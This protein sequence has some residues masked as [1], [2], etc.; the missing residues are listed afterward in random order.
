VL[1]GSCIGAVA[2]DAWII[3]EALFAKLYA[4]RTEY[5]SKILNGG[6]RL[7]G[8]LQCLQQFQVFFSAVEPSTTVSHGV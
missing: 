6:T 2:S 1:P 7:V 4:L 3:Y 5:H 8:N